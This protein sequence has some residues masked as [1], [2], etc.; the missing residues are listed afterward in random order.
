MKRKKNWKIVRKNKN[1][2]K[3]PKNCVLKKIN[4]AMRIEVY[5]KQHTETSHQ[6]CA[7]VCQNTKRGTIVLHI[8]KNVFHI[9]CN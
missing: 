7:F 5:M 2:I 8:D 9:L 4:I 6:N 3:K 1:N